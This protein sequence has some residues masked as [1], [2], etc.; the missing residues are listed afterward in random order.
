MNELVAFAKNCFYSSISLRCVATCVWMEFLTG[1]ITKEAK[2]FAS[3]KQMEYN[4]KWN[5][6]ALGLSI[7]C[8]ICML[9]ASIEK[10]FWLSFLFLVVTMPYLF[11]RVYWA[12][13]SIV[14]CY[15]ENVGLATSLEKNVKAIN[16][17]FFIFRL[18]FD[19]KDLFL[20]Q[21][22]KRNDLTPTVSSCGQKISCIKWHHYA[23]ENVLLFVSFLF[24]MSE[25]M[26]LFYPLK[27]TD[28]H[29]DWPETL[30]IRKLVLIII[31]WTMEYGW[32]GSDHTWSDRKTLNIKRS[33]KENCTFLDMLSND[34]DRSLSQR[35]ITASKEAS[36]QSN[37]QRLSV[38]LLSLRF[39]G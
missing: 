38:I 32:E 15:I 19:A 30:I 39:E 10:Q 9:I 8:A 33:S 5:H 25:Q 16:Q 12:F 36:I 22:A 37:V 34:D 13:N 20:W 31:S 21:K 11:I 24:L 14:D 28:R 1:W 29:D 3:A 6:I 26:T 35:Q 4:Q 27:I 7:E 2:D 17:L 18:S 23:K